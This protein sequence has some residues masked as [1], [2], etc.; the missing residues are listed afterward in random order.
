LLA[1]A[2]RPGGRKPQY[3]E[4]EFLA[5]CAWE[6]HANGLPEKQADLERRMD[7]L[8]PLIWGEEGTPGK[9]WLKEKVK[10]LYE[11]RHAYESGRQKRPGD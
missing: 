9:T 10:R 2:K 4:M 5:L 11:I 7:Q 6:A 8:L 1:P 3:S